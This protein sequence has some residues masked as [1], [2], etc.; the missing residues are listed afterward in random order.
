MKT[1]RVRLE[2]E[3]VEVTKAT[4]YLITPTGD[5]T[6]YNG[7]VAIQSFSA[8]HWVLIEEAV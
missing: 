3:W 8:R 1:Y 4:S 6:I 5:V 2:K 7:S